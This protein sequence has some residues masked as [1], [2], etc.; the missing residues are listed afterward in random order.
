[1][2][3]QLPQSSESTLSKISKLTDE[4]YI[5]INELEER[6]KK[7]V[8]SK[9][10]TFVPFYVPFFTELF[11]EVEDFSLDQKI[12]AT[13]FEFL[14]SLSFLI[15]TANGQVMGALLL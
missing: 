2:N 3:F 15:S 4:N 11:K 5:T 13:D 9:N 12:I 14:E 1:M 7:Y 8:E 10:R 6:S